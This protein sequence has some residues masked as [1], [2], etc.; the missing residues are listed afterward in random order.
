MLRVMKRN[1]DCDSGGTMV[2]GGDSK[3][4]CAADTGS[5]SSAS[6]RQGAAGAGFIRRAPRRR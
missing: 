4:T 5:T 3:A 6:R 2:G 1:A